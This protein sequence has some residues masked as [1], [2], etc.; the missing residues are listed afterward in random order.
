MWE[1]EGEVVEVNAPWASRTHGA[2]RWIPGASQRLPFDM[3]WSLMGRDRVE[4]HYGFGG[5]R[6][7]FESYRGDGPA[8]SNCSAPTRRPFR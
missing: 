2:N 4:A 7:A 6:E 8:F 1:T 3:I 5:N